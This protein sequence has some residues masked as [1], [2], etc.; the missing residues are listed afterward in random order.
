MVTLNSTTPRKKAP[1]KPSK[2]KLTQ[3][4]PFGIGSEV[5]FKADKV[6]FQGTITDII[7]DNI[8]TVAVL[9]YPV[10]FYVP[11]NRLKPAK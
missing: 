9:G 11:L 2:R 8:A 3:S 10:M 5:L 7:R 1:E 4:N 6:T